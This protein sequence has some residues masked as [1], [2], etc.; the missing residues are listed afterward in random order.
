[1]IFTFA[2]SA[3]L[4]F[5]TAPVHSDPPEEVSPLDDMGLPSYEFC[6]DL[7]LNQPEV[8]WQMI[9]KL[10]VVEKAIPRFIEF[11]VLRALFLENDLIIDWYGQAEVTIG[12]PEY[13]LQYAFSLESETIYG[14][15][16][17]EKVI[18]PWWFIGGGILLFGTGFMAGLLLN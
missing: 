1:M 17:P 14:F 10:Y 7:M 6:S 12:S 13:N 5:L 4:L 8:V 9:R 18:S 15:R 2:I 16:E 11:P 3:L